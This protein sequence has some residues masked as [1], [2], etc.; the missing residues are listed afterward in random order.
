MPLK[1][2]KKYARSLVVSCES[3]RMSSDEILKTTLSLLV[4]LLPAEKAYG[5]E[6]SEGKYHF[7]VEETQKILQGKSSTLLY[8]SD[9]LSLKKEK[10]REIL[11]K[12]PNYSLKYVLGDYVNSIYESAASESSHED[13]F[14][15]MHL[16]AI[17]LLQSF[18]QLNFTGPSIEHNYQK[19]LFPN[20][21]EDCL[22][23]EI[24]KL[25]NIEGQQAYD[26][27]VDPILLVLSCITFEKLLGISGEHSIIGR[28][29]SISYD[30]T[31]EAI[32]KKVENASGNPVLASTCWWYSRALQVQGSVLSEM[33]GIIS[34][35]SS[36]LLNPSIITSLFVEGHTGI[37]LRQHVELIFNL[38]CARVAIHGQTENYANKFIRKARR[39][40][41]LELVLT[42][43]KAKKT[44]FQGFF[45]S[46]LVLLA[47]S[48]MKSLYTS[49][50]ELPETFSLNS[51]YLLEMP[52]YESLT[53]VELQYGPEAKKIKMENYF[54]TPDDDQRLIPLATK[55]E[56]IPVI[57]RNI[58]PNNQE[59]LD[60]LDNLQ[61]LLIFT[62]LKQTTP[63]NDVLVEEELFAI[64]ERLIS[65]KHAHINWSIFSR[66][67][68]E[69]SVLETGKPKTVE[70]GIL[71]MTSIIE[72]IG[73]KIRTKVIPGSG[74]QEESQSANR[75]RFVHQ[76]P[77]IPQWTMD[78]KL[79]EKYM[80]LGVLKS[81]L[82]IYERLQF[83][84]EVA[85]CYAATGDEQ[86]AERVISSRLE[87]HPDDARAISILG[88]IKQDPNLWLKAWEVGKYPK[89]KASLSRYLYNPPR[90]VNR[91]VDL[92]IKHMNDSLCVNPLNFENWFFYGCCGLET[93]QYDL[94]SEAFT[95][96]LALD[97]SNAFAAANLA[98]SFIKL[99]K[100][101]QALISLQRAIRNAGDS[102]VLLKLYDNYLTVAYQLESWN[103]VLIAM[104]EIVKVQSNSAGERGIDLPM[105]ESL[106]DVLTSTEYVPDDSSRVPHFQSSCI[107]LICNVLPK[108]ITKSS[109]CW[110]IVSRVELWRKRPWAA[111]E[112]H[113]KAYRALLSEP[114]LEFD[115]KV[116]NDA[117]ESCSDL[118]AAYES[119][120]ELPGKYG[121]GDL[122][123]KD[124]KYK[125]KSV[126]RSLASKG[127]ASWEDT[128][129]WNALQSM[130][131]ELLSS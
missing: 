40:S 21:E 127:K 74:A 98:S 119:L 10:N 63:I 34:K 58:E 56:E 85:L 111:L 25:L 125:A 116:W 91:N 14:L 86:Q 117:V 112:C 35:L 47:K 48:Q 11:S 67:L 126:V 103:D 6:P 51:D 129:G 20:V 83:A 122:V 92:A 8:N 94:A 5:K 46:I 28:N 71:Q 24:T 68:W 53:D 128:E 89:A 52:E 45:A 31:I 72:E 18:I 79:A 69:R 110:R 100:L 59:P 82:E 97:D 123:C 49:G 17:A 102:G 29:G 77:L 57:L 16:L 96:C 26:L 27:M 131:Q 50:N 106:V 81:A 37:V 93:E 65:A 75:L 120:G 7:L 99:G 84:S 33:P 118:V 22:Q 66:A 12:F 13:S 124:W 104:R 36:I 76:L 73:I 62:I 101:K 38:E 19:S 39:I 109:R 114:N 80:S 88:D 70:R 42:G 107:D 55:T 95:R 64:L 105:L 108:V 30:T 2:K 115:E 78:V 15:K 113:E 3:V 90:G 1:K 23:A 54:E 130:K 60:D 61:L 87:K 121:A 43:A 44:R 9:D 32:E 4:I 41:G